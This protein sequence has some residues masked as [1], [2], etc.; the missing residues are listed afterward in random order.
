MKWE[1]QIR[2]MSILD[3]LPAPQKLLPPGKEPWERL[4]EGVNLDGPDIYAGNEEYHMFQRLV[5]DADDWYQDPETEIPD[6]K[7][8]IDLGNYF[9]GYTQANVGTDSPQYQ[10]LVR[11]MSR[12]I[13][14]EKEINELAPERELDPALEAEIYRTEAKIPFT[15]KDQLDSRHLQ[16]WVDN[17]MPG[18][19]DPGLVQQMFSAVNTVIEQEQFAIYG[20]EQRGR[21]V[22]ARAAEQHQNHLALF[23][24]LHAHYLEITND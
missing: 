6:V 4:L 12:L 22:P 14:I 17:D 15:E 13:G 16:E 11:T 20:F 3:T 2:N 23:H 8:A 21:S 19:D 5:E 18:Y 1:E 10:N 7:R 9:L 24:N